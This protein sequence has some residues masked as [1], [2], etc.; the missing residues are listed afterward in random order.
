MTVRGALRRCALLVDAGVALAAD[1]LT[2][3]IGG[4]AYDGPPK[5]EVWFDGERLG[6]G[7]VDAA[8]DTATTG[9]FATTTVKAPYIESFDFDIPD[10][11]FNAG[12]EVRVRFLNEAY[13]GDGSNRDRNLYLASVAIN[14]LEVPATE[15]TTQSQA[16]IEPSAILGDFLVLF[17][18]TADGV[19]AAPDMGWPEPGVGSGCRAGGGAGACAGARAGTC[20]RGARAG[21]RGGCAGARAGG[22]ACTGTRAVAEPV[23]PRVEPEAPAEPA[24]AVAQPEPERPDRSGRNRSPARAGRNCTARGACRSG[25]GAR[26]EARSARSLSR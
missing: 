1:K 13:G 12:G 8:I 9:R 17:D 7:V 15:M 3:V 18:G 21:R 11:V 20:G 2:L 4:E 16:G 24:V 5:F 23:E 14:G 10:A 19:A 22:G 6:E 26:S 25:A